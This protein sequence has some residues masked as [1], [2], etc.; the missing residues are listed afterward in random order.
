MSY[1]DDV[2][3]S[4]G[5]VDNVANVLDRQAEENEDGS[6]AENSLLGRFLATFVNEYNR[7]KPDSFSNHDMNELMYRWAAITDQSTKAIAMESRM[8]TDDFTCNNGA[9]IGNL[10][11]ETL[12]RQN[13][14]QIFVS[15]P[16]FGGQPR[17]NEVTIIESLLRFVET[18]ARLATA[19]R[20]CWQW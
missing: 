6:I 11:V 19:V 12:D 14:M 4:D 2:P 15:S 10:Q 5:V 17:V 18:L 3:N 16:L 9:L 1:L 7:L 20:P 8:R 13:R